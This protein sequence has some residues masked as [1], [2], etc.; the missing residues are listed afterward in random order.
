MLGMAALSPA[1]GQAIA[2][3][4]QTLDTWAR[5][6]TQA[7]LIQIHWF[8]LKLDLATPLQHFQFPP[9]NLSFWEFSNFKC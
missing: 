5:D 1:T 3:L 6:P 9:T 8:R 4:S 2:K 7:P